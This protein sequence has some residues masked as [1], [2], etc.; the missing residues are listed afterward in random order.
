MTRKPRT[1]DV[2]RYTDL[3]AAAAS[4][5]EEDVSYAV[6]MMQKARGIKHK[7][8]ICALRK[9]L[10]KAEEAAQ[11]QCAEEPPFWCRT[12]SPCGTGSCL[13]AQ[14]DLA[15]LEVPAK[16]G[17]QRRPQQSLAPTYRLETAVGPLYELRKAAGALED[18]EEPA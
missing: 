18:T 6:A 7:R 5:F 11:A 15:F 13:F 4:A 9:E 3:V 16:P 2:S 17:N 8:E 1:L 10:R 12:Q 14:G